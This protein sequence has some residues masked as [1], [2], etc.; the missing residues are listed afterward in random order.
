MFA[1]YRLKYVD[2]YI[3]RKE[4][5]KNIMKL[6]MKNKTMIG[7][8]MIAIVMI[9]LMAIVPGISARE[10]NSTN[11]VIIIGEENI[12]FE[13][14][15]DGVVTGP[16]NDFSD[17]GKNSTVINFVI[18]ID[19]TEYENEL[20]QAGYLVFNTT[21]SFTVYFNRPLFTMETLTIDGADEEIT[22]CVKGSS[23]NI[24]VKTNLENINNS[25]NALKVDFKITDP[26][27]LA[28]DRKNVFLDTTGNTEINFNGVDEVGE[29][30]VYIATDDATCNGLD[31]FSSNIT[32]NVIESGVTMISNIDI[33]AKTGE[34]IFTGTT[35]PKEKINLTVDSGTKE[36]VFFVGGK[37]QLDTDHIGDDIGLINVTSLKTGTFSFVCNFSET[38]S[39]AIKATDEDGNSAKVTV[40][41]ISEIVTVKTSKSF[42]CIGE[43]IEIFGSSNIGDIASISIDDELVNNATIKEDGTFNYKWISSGVIGSHKVTV[44]IAN[45]PG[46][47]NIADATTSFILTSSELVV[48]VNKNI[49]ALEDSFIISGFAKGTNQI[50]IITFAPKG[51]NNN[52][53]DGQKYGA[54][55]TIY[56]ISVSQTNGYFEKKIDISEEADCGI[57]Y[58]AIIGKGNDGYYGSNEIATSLSLALSSYTFTNKIQTQM[59]AMLKDATIDAVASDDMFFETTIKVE[60]PSI[61]INPISQIYIGETLTISGTYNRE[62][63]PLTITIERIGLHPN[64]IYTSNLITENNSFS[65]NI[66]TSK[67]D[68][69]KYSIQVDDSDGFSDEIEIV[70][71]IQSTPTVP[72]P[73]PIVT[74]TPITKPDITPIPTETS[75]PETLG[76]E[77]IFAIAGLL[78]IAYL[79]LRKRK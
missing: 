29:Y 19:T 51:N 26:K 41:I 46:S 52:R 2:N 69:S 70:A 40:N 71:L 55:Y 64:A 49:V 54:D 25:E 18:N 9:T 58:L 5:I 35:N 75:T 43:E 78:L 7:I 13:N 8:A 61:T 44:E 20:V 79:M 32:F 34:V 60:T 72:Q 17:T 12:S 16:I 57:H 15:I 77:A 24:S 6:K 37:G 39:Y 3:L 38:G 74:Q 48:T 1:L 22:S 63:Y 62:K 68:L 67:W 36:N 66:D 56:T 23:I 21:T 76:F 11:N 73:T 4:G 45:L 28:R 10:V 33:Q 42:Y 53:L 50:E 27:G 30:T 47:D 59:I 31:V 14:I 65:I